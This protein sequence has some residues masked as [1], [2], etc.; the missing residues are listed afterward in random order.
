SK[1]TVTVLSALERITGSVFMTELRDF[2]ESVKVV[3]GKISEKAS[4]VQRLIA[5]PTTGFILVTG[6]DEAKLEEA[7]SLFQ[8][9]EGRSFTRAA[10]IVNRA[11]PKWYQHEG[12]VTESSL[13]R[14]YEA[15]E[16]YHAERERV[17]NRFAGK[18]SEVLPTVRIPDL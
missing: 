6:F 10:A 17:F 9:L 11:F 16:R 18:W 4:A 1:G 8:Y 2:F 13:R 7:E 5:E 14:E 3:Q 12:P 15:W